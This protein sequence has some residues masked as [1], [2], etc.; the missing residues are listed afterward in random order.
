[1]ARGVSEPL[2]TRPKLCMRAR[3]A[4][5]PPIIWK[6]S[7]FPRLG[8]SGKPVASRRLFGAAGF[9]K[10]SGA[11]PPLDE[12]LAAQRAQS[13]CDGRAGNTNR[14]TSWASLGMRPSVPNRPASTSS[15][16]VRAI[17]SNVWSFPG[18]CSWWI[19][20]SQVRKI[21]ITEMFRLV[22]MRFAGLIQSSNVSHTT[23]PVPGS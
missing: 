18:S 2:H 14:L 4:I 10:G 23:R 12:P 1:M 22:N 6:I 8:M 16:R 13:P 9:Y 7:V 3:L 21:V 15:R 11:D 5:S 20:H 19:C 17:S